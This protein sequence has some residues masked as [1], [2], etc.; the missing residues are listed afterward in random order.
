MGGIRSLSRGG[1]SEF[2]FY[3]F[4]IGEGVGVLYPGTAGV[5]SFY[6]GCAWHQASYMSPGRG[7]FYYIV[8]GKGGLISI[9]VICTWDLGGGVRRS[10]Y[11]AQLEKHPLMV[12]V[13]GIRP[14]KIKIK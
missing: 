12:V 9:C 2:H 14:P 10:D 7:S 11:L 1:G 5:A 13:L 6:G 3:Y 4:G 8:T